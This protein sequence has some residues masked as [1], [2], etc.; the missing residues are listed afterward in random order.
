MQA[1]ILQT[2]DPRD[3]G[4]RIQEARKTR[5]LTQGQVAEQL[6]MARTTVTAIE[7][8]ERRIQPEE[9]I[10][11][12][13]LLGRSIGEFFRR[14]TP[15]ESFAVQFRATLSPGKEIA[16]EITPKVLEFQ[17]LCEDYRELEEICVAPLPRRY[18]PPYAIDGVQPEEAAEDVASAE[19]NR[20]GLGDGPIPNLRELLESSVGLRIFYMDD[21]PYQFSA[22]F[23][24]SD[25]LGGC[26]AV[27]AKH[28]EE[29]RRMSLAHDYA[30]FLTRRYQSEL[31]IAGMY[32]RN[33]LHERFA[34]A[35][36]RTFLMPA[37][38]VSR[39]FHEVRRSRNGATPTAADVLTMAH[40]YFVSMEAMTRRLEELRLLSSGTWERLRERG[41]KVQEAQQKLGLI[42]R[43]EN[44]AL[45]PMRFWFLAVEALIEREELTEKQFADFLRIDWIEGRRI[46]E[47]FENN[48]GEGAEL[49]PLSRS[50]ASRVEEKA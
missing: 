12:A 16:P 5:G 2:I 39:Q 15:P 44:D 9:L 3:L 46:A 36:A 42:Q 49:L 33:P 47:S 27:N 19:R 43:A 37:A 14:G 22:M 1:D 50:A 31:D 34:D 29:R 13:P 40:H 17:R 48:T 18:P 38:G 4:R 24:Y 32:T 23:N 26:I 28:I 21:L 11:L 10:R 35:F 45:L 41:F 8:G 25:E 6:D 7:K 30:H 20:L